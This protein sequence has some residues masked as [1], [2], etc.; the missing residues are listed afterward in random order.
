M[1]GLSGE[2]A[3]DDAANAVRAVEELSSD[4]AHAIQIGDGYHLFVRGNLKDAVAGGVHDGLA[5]TNVLFTKL[6]D[7]FRAG[8]GFVT[9][10]FATDL[11]F[12]LVDNF[13]RKSM[14]VD[15]KCLVEPNAGHFPMTGGRILSG[16]MRGAFSVAD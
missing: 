9:Q 5:G 6:L 11:P 10:G 3:S 13:A 4:L 2:W 7:D 15:R 12:E 1:S 14:R 8:G 16:R